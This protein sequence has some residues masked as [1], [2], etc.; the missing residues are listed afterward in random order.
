MGLSNSNFHQIKIIIS[1]SHINTFL[2]IFIF[3]LI[4]ALSFNQKKSNNKGNI[5]LLNRQTKHS[6]TGPF[7]AV[8]CVRQSYTI[9]CS[10]S[11]YFQILCIFAKNFKYFALFKHF[12]PFFWKIAH[13]PLL[14]RVG[15]A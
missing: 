8:Y 13:M 14:F 11:K 9:N 5:V 4:R 12:L 1:I 10:F 7:L 15:P 6:I 3:L 2:Q